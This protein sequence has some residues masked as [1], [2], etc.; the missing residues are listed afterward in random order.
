MLARPVAR[1][2][3][4]ADPPPG[5][6]ALAFPPGRTAE[7]FVVRGSLVTVEAVAGGGGGWRTVQIRKVPIEYGSSS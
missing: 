7:A 1:W 5:S 3:R 2:R 4:L 6:Q